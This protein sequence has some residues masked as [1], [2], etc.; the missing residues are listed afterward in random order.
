MQAEKSYSGRPDFKAWEA[1][2]NARLIEICGLGIE[3]LPD[4]RYFDE[5]NKGTS[6][7]KCADDALTH[8]HSY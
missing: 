6:E 7:K 2:V 3:D 8:A 5:Y 1:A 4:Y